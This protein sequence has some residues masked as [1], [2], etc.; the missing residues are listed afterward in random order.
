MDSSADPSQSQAPSP[1]NPKPTWLRGLAR[2][3]S[4]RNAPL[5]DLSQLQ[6]NLPKPSH[7]HPDQ[8]DHPPHISQ[9]DPQP[10]T[11]L[12]EIA[13]PSRDP[14]DHVRKSLNDPVNASAFD[15]LPPPEVY[16][17]SWNTAPLRA[18]AG[19]LG[20]DPRAAKGSVLPIAFTLNSSDLDDEEEEEDDDD[21]NDHDNN[22]Q[23]LPNTSSNIPTDNPASLTPR[24]VIQAPLVITSIDSTTTTSNPSPKP[25]SPLHSAKR[26]TTNVWR[27]VANAQ[28]ARTRLQTHGTRKPGIFDS[29]H[30]AK[31]TAEDLKLILNTDLQAEI[32][33]DKP[34]EIRA[35]VPV[36][37]NHVPSLY[38][39]VIALEDGDDTCKVSI[40]RSFADSFRLSNEDFDWFCT[41]F[42]NRFRQLRQIAQ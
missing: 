23:S 30:S 15:D 20:S 12:V 31:V 21:D 26:T 39:F 38:N 1:R 17:S 8:P 42:V 18:E 29:P 19:Q 16:D 33:T 25:Q 36:T 35:R 4:L 9:P 34:T 41:D 22:N 10:P 7:D 28:I 24:Q 37:I 32:T 6:T 13:P 14:N 40:R 2:R 27:R 11:P 5:P 3:V